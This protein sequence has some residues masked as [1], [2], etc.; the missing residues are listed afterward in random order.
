MHT[1]RRFVSTLA[2]LASLVFLTACQS[3][4]GPLAPVVDGTAVMASGQP[5]MATAAPV[6]QP[7]TPDT[8]TTTAHVSNGTT[9]ALLLP[10]QGQLASVSSAIRAGFN[11]AYQQ[12]TQADKPQLRIYD[13]SGKAITDVYAQAIH[14]GASTIVGPLEKQDVQ[15]L[16]DQGVDTFTLA[17]NEVPTM[18]PPT[19]FY[20]YGLAPQDEAAQLADKLWYQGYSNPLIIAPDSAWG[21]TTLTAY[22][23]A[24][25]RD[26]GKPLAQ[27][28]YHL[29]GDPR[30]SITAALAPSANAQGTKTVNGHRGDIDAIVLIANPEQ[31]YQIVPLLTAKAADLPIYATSNLYNGVP[32]AAA[33]QALNGVIFADIPAI[34]SPQTPQLTQLATDMQTWQQSHPNGLIR[35]YAFGYDAY[36]LTQQHSKLATPGFSYAGATGNLYVDNQQLL[37]RRLAWGRF[38]NGLVV[39]V[40]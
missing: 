8:S 40:A 6:A 12:N 9:I 34:V 5:V 3:S 23:Q 19:N 11:D 36:Q 37:H 22:T 25:Q 33:N 24:W 16:A 2:L 27:S 18:S 14:D 1:I 26:G 10:A 15:A 17:L 21:Q 4:D 7:I 38:D 35:L 32:N 13:T 28:V 39:P 20:Q 31:A 30:P 29:P